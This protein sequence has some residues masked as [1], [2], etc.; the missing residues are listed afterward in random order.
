MDKRCNNAFCVLFFEDPAKCIK[1]TRP[2]ERWMGHDGRLCISFSNNG[3]FQSC[4][5]FPYNL[6]IEQESVTSYSMST[7]L[8]SHFQKYSSFKF[9]RRCWRRICQRPIQKVG[10]LPVG[11]GLKMSFLHFN[12]IWSAPV[13]HAAFMFLV[14]LETPT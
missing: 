4:F 3:N 5:S 8:N 9:L 10:V 11:F 6:L 1:Q 14:Y 13:N 12:F 2:K 7:N